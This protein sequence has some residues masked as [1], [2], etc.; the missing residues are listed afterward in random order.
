MI[1]RAASPLR[2]LIAIAL[3]TVGGQPA[4]AI[5]QTTDQ[6][7]AG[8]VAFFM[9]SGCPAG[10]SVATIAQG[11]LLLGIT[12]PA[13]LGV[14]A[15]PPLADGTAPVHLHAYQTTVA[16]SSKH[17]SAAHGANHQG[18]QNGS[19]DVPSNP[20]G[21]TD[22]GTGAVSNLPFIQLVVCQKQ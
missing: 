21:Q 4:A 17:I 18:A 11:R 2:R 22:G 1:G 10:W 5:A 8:M 19:Y 16:L 6:T 9:A 13:G 7:P 14:T 3:C 20:P 15:G 12:N